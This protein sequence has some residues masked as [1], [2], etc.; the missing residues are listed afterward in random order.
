MESDVNNKSN[1]DIIFLNESDSTKF[2]LFSCSDDE[3]KV[4]KNVFSYMITRSDEYNMTESNDDDESTIENNQN[5][6]T[7][8]NNQNKSTIEN[9]QN[10][11]IIEN[12]QDDTN[13][14]YV[15]DEK[16]MIGENDNY[17]AEIIRKDM[18]EEFIVYIN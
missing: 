1:Y 7:I 13:I 4:S 14:F 16:R 8:E 18:I 9:N 3:N 5:K 15:D 2:N 17:F 11:S 10:E 6:S 12:N